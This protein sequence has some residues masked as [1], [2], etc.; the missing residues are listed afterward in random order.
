M[1]IH[2]PQG[3]WFCGNSSGLAN[4]TWLAV[5]WLM[6]MEDCGQGSSNR[7]VLS[8]RRGICCR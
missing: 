5:Q 2:S 6:L 4:A 3:A 7:N 8:S 1:I